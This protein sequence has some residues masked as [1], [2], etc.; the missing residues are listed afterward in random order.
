M[1]TRR[2]TVRRLEKK[3]MNEEIP[4]QVEKVEQV[5][6]GGKGI[7]GAQGSQ[8]PPQGYTIPNKEGVLRFQR[9]LIGRLEKL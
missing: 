6:Q 3:R 5:P 2:M 7:Q 1:N 9:C 8:V 4:L